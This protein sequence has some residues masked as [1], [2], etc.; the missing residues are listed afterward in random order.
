MAGNF[1][2]IMKLRF[3]AELAVDAYREHEIT[4]GENLVILKHDKDAYNRIW[5]ELHKVNEKNKANALVGKDNVELDVTIDIHYKPRTLKMNA[6][7]WALYAIIAIVMN[8]ENK[9]RNPVTAQYL[10]DVDMEDLAPRKVCLCSQADEPFFVE[11]LLEKYDA[12]YTRSEKDGVIYL[13][14]LE[15]TRYWNTMMMSEHIDRLFNTLA[16]MGVTKETNGDVDA[17]FRDVEKWKAQ[18]GNTKEN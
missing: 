1:K 8:R 12:I 15:T 13:T 6:L 3:N 14:V 16:D 5:K 2:E 7:M 9:T 17:I 11:A 4:R 10:H 18:N